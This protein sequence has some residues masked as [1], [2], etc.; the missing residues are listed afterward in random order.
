[1]DEQVNIE[2]LKDIVK[3]FCDDRDWGQ[4]RSPKELAIGAVTE[5]AE[6]LDLF[7]FKSDEEIK[8]MLEDAQKRERISEELSD[9]LFFVIRFCQKYDF[10]V[11]EC[12]QNKIN[13]NAL[14]YPIEKAKGQNKKYNEL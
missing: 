2:E 10:D 1:M 14:K 9:V 7:R 5:S 13:K 8:I 4:F 11:F 6:L 3:K 12:F